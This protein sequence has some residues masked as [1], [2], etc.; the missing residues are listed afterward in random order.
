MATRTIHSWPRDETSL[1]V[2]TSANSV[3]DHAYGVPVDSGGLVATE[4]GATVTHF[5]N[6]LPRSSDER[7]ATVDVASATAPLKYQDGYVLDAGDRLVTTTVDPTTP[8]QGGFVR[9]ADGAMFIA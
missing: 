9:D 7:L 1:A 8:P 4:A 2:M 5:Q 3:A 6:G